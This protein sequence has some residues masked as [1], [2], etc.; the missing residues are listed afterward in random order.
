MAKD[1][2]S[3]RGKNSVK[4]RATLNALESQLEA[5]LPSLTGRTALFGIL[6]LKKKGDVNGLMQMSR[7]KVTSTNPPP[8][9]LT[10]YGNFIST[11]TWKDGV[12]KAMPFP[13]QV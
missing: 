2:L 11:W 7:S 13:T 3:R 12:L 10:K 6:L 5:T 1:T 4:Y 9:R 8:S